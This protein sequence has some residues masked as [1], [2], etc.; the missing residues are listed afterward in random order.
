M[1]G[2]AGVLLLLKRPIDTPFLRTDRILIGNAKH[3]RLA[4]TLNRAT[5]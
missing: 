5:R 3:H 1:R 4:D 2:S